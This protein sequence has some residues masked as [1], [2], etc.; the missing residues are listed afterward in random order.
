MEVKCL[1]KGY[2]RLVDSMGDD[3]SIVRAAR[4]SF[5]ADWRAGQDEGS[6]EKLIRYLLKNKHSTPFEAVTIT[7]E[8]KAPIFVFRQWHRHRTWAYNEVSGRYQE[9]S[10]FHL[11]SIETIARQSKSNKQGRESEAM[12]EGDAYYVQTLLEAN[13]KACFSSYRA[14][15][16][17][18]VAREMAREVLPVATYSRMFAT[19][20]LWNLLKFITLRL[21]SHAQY[22]IQVYAAACYA[23]AGKVAPIAV[24]AFEALGYKV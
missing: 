8:V 20:N 22:E 2:V 5:D 11:P 7:M 10:E 13:H 21:D 24:S 12:E 3:L 17:A 15:L 18:G 9:L 6:D 14:L 19:V 16:E 1:D 4:V 23:I